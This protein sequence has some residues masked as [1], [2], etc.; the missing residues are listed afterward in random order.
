MS[1]STTNSP[2][3]C[4]NAPSAA[5]PAAER[6]LS[7][8]VALDIVALLDITAVALGSALPAWIYAHF[9]EVAVDWPVVA[10][11]A[12][13]AGF[14]AHLMLRNAGLYDTARTHDLP[15]PPMTLLLA[16]LVAV[17]C[18]VGLGLPIARL[19]WHVL[20]WYAL[21]MSA[22]YT[23]ILVTRG[24]SQMVLARLTS[25]GR[26]ERRVAVFGAGRIARR[27]H[28]YLAASNSGIRFSGLYDDR[29]GDE[30]L[31]SA[32]MHVDG[33]LADLLDAAQA[34]RLDEIIIALPQTAD[35][36]IAG[37]VR[38][39]DRAPCSVHIVTHIAS[40]YIDARRALR[41]SSI[42][43][44]GLLDVKERPLSDWAPLVKRAEDVVISIIGLVLA[45]P[46]LAVAIVAIKLESRGPAFYR[47]GRRGLNR[48]IIGVLKLRT[49]K[50]TEAD[51]EVRQV[52]PGDDRLTRTGAFLRRASIDELPQLWNVL[53][54]EMS[55]VG[56]RPHALVHDE[57]FSTMLEE[58]SNRHQVKPGITGLAQVEGFRGQ[59]LTMEQIEGRVAQDI[60]Y[61]KTWSLWLDL[62]IIARTLSIVFSG[63]NAH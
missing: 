23:M 42:G 18:V 2:A 57:Q 25:A 10:R 41:V 22:S 40:D 17:G 36:R 48:R 21:W 8:N 1:T 56:P 35:G 59:T 60:A 53:K 54:G 51:G 26:F 50:V 13:V 34:E 30:R 11:A 28:D 24:V 12:L 38:R 43:G 9:G 19:Q 31:D 39:L 6:S 29:L 20:L 45:V 44:V 55:I 49:L 58:Y 16:L 33:R 47:Q 63:K 5:I 37:I 32:G 7:R 27:V 46:I 62:R 52:T 61:I 4:D 15:N 3:A 14:I